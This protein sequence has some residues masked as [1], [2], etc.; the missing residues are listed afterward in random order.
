MS[1]RLRDLIK[2]AR[3]AKTA[4]EEREI[5]QKEQAAIRDSF[6][7]EEAEYRHRNVAKLLYISM[8]GYNTQYGQMETLKLIASNFY[9]DKRIGYLAL[10]LL[11][12]EKQEILILV[13]S[14]MKNDLNSNNQFI[15]GLALCALGNISSSGIA[16]DLAPDVEKLLGSTNPYLR[17]KAALCAIRVLRKCPDLMENFVPRIRSLLS[18]RNHG[19]LLT[20][21]TL[22]TELCETDSH[23][24]EF[25]KRLVPTLVRILKNLVM[26]GYAPEYDVNGIT[27]PYLQV[28]ILKLLRILGKGDSE[29]TDIMNDILAQV[30]TNTDH[31]R[32][33][34]NAVLYECVQTIMNIEAE[35]GLRLLAINVLGRFLANKDNNIRYVALAT[36]GK[37]VSADID[38]VQRHRNT[39][40]DCLKDPDTS[41]R[42]R[43][44]EL[45]YSL[46]NE[47]NIKILA[48]EL[49]IFLQTASV[50]FRSDLA[51]NLCRVTEKF[52]PNKRWHVDTIL[53]VLSIAGNCVSDEVCSNL[54][55]LIASSPELHSYAV[56]K[57]VIALTNDYTQQTLVQVAAWTIGEFGDLLLTVP[58]SEREI[59]V[60]ESDVI[61]LLDKIIRDPATNALSKDYILTALMKLTSRFSNAQKL[62]SVIARYQTNMDLELQSRAVEYT[63]LFG[64]EAVRDSLL[65]RIPVLEQREMKSASVTSPTPSSS[66]SSRTQAPAPKKE[67]SL[68]D[69]ED[70]LPSTTTTNTSTSA[71]A[72]VA[73]PAGLDILSEIFGGPAPSAAP[74]AP[75]SSG[76]DFLTSLTPT[77]SAAPTPVPSGPPVLNGPLPT[78]TVFQSPSAI[79]YFDVLKQSSTPNITVVNASFANPSGSSVQNF[80]FKVAVPKHIKLQVNPPSGNVLPPHN[81]GRVTQAFKLM[82]TLHGEKPL[83]LK[84]KMDYIRDG[85]PVSEMT[86][87]SFPEGC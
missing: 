60:S 35:D 37:V 79:I 51:V 64:W 5:I 62:R 17:K 57:M 19:V 1:K 36:L 25:F 41:I 31:A 76:L 75:S 52:S 23:N 87:V 11:L 53:R 84:I 7:S 29:S 42:K 54:V 10:M 21:V 83:L 86:D 26:S 34:G 39:I 72:P 48:H 80:D 66:S 45:I 14:H 81:S 56:Q 40:V 74:V 43:A 71:P 70:D 33:V 59:T 67:A 63:K 65:E 4:A 58:A 18:D 24:I 12:D 46:V 30:A 6:R 69:W 44:L 20:G 16:R 32:N 22:M 8:L 49:I 15:A 61:D 28:R 47:S 38:A 3:A 9:S 73:A 2:V 82:N 13:T 78:M 68:L 85:A 27:D 55:G 50:E 77:P